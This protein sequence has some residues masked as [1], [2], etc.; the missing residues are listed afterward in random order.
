M[1]DQ[2]KENKNIE[3]ETNKPVNQE[4]I[5][6]VESIDTETIKPKNKNDYKCA[7]AIKFNTG[8]CIDLPVLVE[9][10]N[11]YNETNTQKI[12]LHPK[13]Q[14]LNPKKYKKYL[15]KEFKN[16]YENVCDTQFCWTQQDFV[17]KMN[18]IMKDELTKFT[19][20]PQGPTGKFEWLNTNH[21]NDVMEQ[22]QKVHKDF[23]FLGAVPMDFDSLPVLGIKDINLDDH[24]NKGITKF[25]IIFN[26][27]EHWQA[28]SH[29]VAGYS[30][31]KNGKAYFF[32]SYGVA[33]DDRARKLLRR[34]AK[35]SEDKFKVKIDSTHNQTR[36]QYGNSECGMYSLN[37]ILELLEGKT[38]N[39]VCSSK[40]PDTKVNQLRPVFFYN[41]NF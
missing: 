9:M 39:D 7:P 17:D 4:Q 15:L 5:E 34:F 3:L 6:S 29:W 35:Y 12:K 38:F 22:Y 14:T 11:A 27:D 28:G 8:S 20:R 24:I 30:D 13:L 19:Y 25:G 32:D 40:I 41:V 21:L 33:P 36:H 18:G 10:A 23:K 16:R 26:L 37:F 2:S 31:L 1:S